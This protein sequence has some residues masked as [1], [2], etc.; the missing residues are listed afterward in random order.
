MKPL[1]SVL[2]VSIFAL[3]AAGV[4]TAQSNPF[5]GT[6]KLNVPASKFDPG[7]APQSQTRVWEADGKITVTGVTAAGKSVTYNYTIAGDGKDYPTSGAIPNG[8]DQVSSKKVNANTY[9]AKFTKAGKQVEETTFQVSKD[10][11]SLTILIK[12]VLPTGQA[13]N[14]ETHWDKQ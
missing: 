2:I 3:V 11:N 8:S 1:R 14:N 7:P 12:G 10:G 6:W 13:M 5:V 9:T 4:A